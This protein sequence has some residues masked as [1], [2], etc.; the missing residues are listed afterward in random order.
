MLYKEYAA[1]ELAQAHYKTKTKLA[2]DII[3]DTVKSFKL[4]MVIGDAHFAT[5]AMLD[6]I[7]P[8]KIDFLMKTGL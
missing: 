3:D 8:A 2:I 6:F 7:C 5:N 4:N 1:V